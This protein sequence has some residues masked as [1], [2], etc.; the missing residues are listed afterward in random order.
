MKSYT[1]WEEVKNIKIDTAL[2]GY[3]IAL[4]TPGDLAKKV[5]KS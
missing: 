4:D 3:S 1:A 2:R 5:C